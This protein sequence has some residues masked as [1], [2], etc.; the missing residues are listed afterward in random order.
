MF[1]F[2]RIVSIKDGDRVLEIGPGGTPHPRANTFLDVHPDSFKDEVEAGY[3]R[4]NA[5]ELRTDKPMVYY[6]GTH[7][8]FKDNEFDYVICTHVLEHVDNLDEFLKELFRIGKMGYVEYPTMLY[9]YLYN[10]PVHVNFLHY[11]PETN[12]L[13]YFKKRD[14]HLQE[15]HKAQR[16]FEETLKHNHVTMLHALLPYFVEGFEW[17]QPFELRQAGQL[18]ELMPDH[19]TIK[20]YASPEDG[21]GLKKASQLFAQAIVRKASHVLRIG[22]K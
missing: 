12:R 11:Q 9:D 2:D 10:I 3:Q 13:L 7:M 5:E 20:T 16:F 6:D 22:A 4:G 8:P 21:V 1:Y 18:D 15:F 19:F 14:T 17:R